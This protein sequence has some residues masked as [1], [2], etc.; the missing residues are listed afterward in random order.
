MVFIKNLPISGKI[1]SDHKE[2]DPV[3]SIRGRKTI[4][5]T[6]EY[7]SD[8]ILSET[9]TSRAEIDLLPTI[10]NLYWQLMEQG[11]QPF[12]HMIDNDC[13]DLMKCFIRET[14]DTHQLVPQGLH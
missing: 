14:G 7:D 13:S 2:R 6:E 4:I 12:L 10:T 5:F 9:L 1:Y 11:L 3:T 8:G